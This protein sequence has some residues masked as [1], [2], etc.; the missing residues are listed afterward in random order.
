MLRESVLDTPGRWL[1]RGKCRILPFGDVL[2]DTE[3]K[4]Q[5]CKPVLYHPYPHVSR[6]VSFPYPALCGVAKEKLP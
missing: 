1:G 2:L 4:Y 5:L 6:T 3:F